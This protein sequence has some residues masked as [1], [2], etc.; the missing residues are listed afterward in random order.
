[1][2]VDCFVNYT[3]TT[4]IYTYCH[5]LARHDALP[6][7]WSAEVLPD[8]FDHHRRGST[9][10]A[11]RDGLQVHP[12]APR[13]VRGRHGGRAVAGGRDRRARLR[14]EEHT[15]ELQSLMRI[16]YAVFCLKKK[17]RRR[18]CQRSHA[19]TDIQKTA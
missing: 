17:N 5:P 18:P 9:P 1:M 12:A 19:Y 7:A 11:D 13:A 4:E 6:V 3:V 2:C 14:S 16:P 8:L 15:S 10:A